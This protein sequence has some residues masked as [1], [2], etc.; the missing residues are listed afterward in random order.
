[1]DQEINPTPK[2]K[3]SNA[4]KFWRI[5]LGTMVGFLF[6]SIIASIFSTI[7]FIA[8]IAS[9]SNIETVYVN[10]NSILK[11]DL[12]Q[13]IVEQGEDNPFDMFGDEFSQ[14][15]QTTIGLDDILSCIKSATNDPKIKGIYLNTPTLNCGWSTAR[16]IRQALEEFKASGKFIYAYADSYSQGGYYLASVADE[17]NMSTT[18]I[19]E[20]KGLSMQVLFFKGLLDKLDVDVQIIRHGKFKSA[21]EPYMMDRMSDANREQMTLL[22]NA[23]WE[24]AVKDISASRKLSAETLNTIADEILFGTAKQAIENKLIDK[25]CY[26]SDVVA[27]LMKLVNVTS[28]DDLYLTSI[29]EYKKAL[30]NDG[31]DASD[32]I[33]IIYANGQIV[34]GNST[35]GYMGSETMVKNIKDAYTNDKVKAIVFRVNSPGGDGTASDIIWHEI[36]QAKKAGKI[37]V[38]SMGDYAASGGYY[39]SCNSDYIIAQPNTLTGSIGVFGMVPSFQK[40]LKNKLGVTIDGVST[41][42]HSDANGVLQPL[43][44]EELA[45]WQNFVDEF[46]GVFTQRVADGRGM[47]QDAVDSIGQGRVWAGADAINIG[48]VDALGN[49]NDAIAKAAELAKIDNYKV[50]YYPEKMDF[51]AKLMGNKKDKDNIKAL[52]KNELGDQYYIYEGLNQLKKAEGVQALMP[53]QIMFN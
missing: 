25:A 22:A 44:E 50:V 6:S 45:I 39:I 48:L 14:F 34:G 7:M 4:K 29:T 37:V 8:M 38:T 16:E 46:Y 31:N 43:D 9:L 27:D 36:E 2:K 49:I 32:E 21:V 52:I 15:Y 19:M 5:V 41:N 42:K 28:E 13:P 3:E 33:A 18:G 17:V 10:D 35:E 30:V 26:K 47:T 53:M 23:L 12:S 20:F 24:T 51:F 1:M 11:L 40:T